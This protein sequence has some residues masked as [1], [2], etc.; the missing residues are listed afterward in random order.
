MRRLVNEHVLVLNKFFLA[1]QVTIAK[2]AV[3]ALVT[4]KAQVTDKEYNVY[5]LEQW[6]EYTK[7]HQDEADDYTGIMRSPSVQIFVPQVIRIPDCEF[8]NPVIKT[9]KYSRRN[10]YQ[11]DENT[12]QYCHRK[13]PKDKLTL[14][15]VVPKSRGG[16]SSWTNVVTCCK[17]C[18]ECKG[19]RLLEELGW[20]LDKAP[21]RPRWKSHIGVPFNKTRKDYWNTFLE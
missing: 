2:E 16:K 9:I 3:C 19:N 14:D 21:T 11:R 17:R 4:G 18:N 5:N 15:H 12:C 7:Q 1:I 8:N 20:K 6:K 13:F 10:V